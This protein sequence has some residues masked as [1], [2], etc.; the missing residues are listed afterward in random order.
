[1]SA[2]AVRQEIR[3]LAAAGCAVLVSSHVMPEVAAMCDRV[4]VLASGR[5]AATGTPAEL[6]AE[7]GCA[8]LEEAFV[9]IIGSDEGLN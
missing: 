2:R 5:V 7:T 9:R 4:V 3:R 8:T 1:M 6:M